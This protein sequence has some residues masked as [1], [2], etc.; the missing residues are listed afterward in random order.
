[1]NAPS[2]PRGRSALHR[3]TLLVGGY[4]AL[5]LLTI[6]VVALLPDDPAIVNDTVWVRGDIV[7]ASAL[8]TLLFTLRA[9]RGSRRAFL[10]L[11]IISAVM[12]VAVA[13]IVG[14]PGFLPLWMRVEQSVCGLLLLGVVVVVNG[15]HL[16]SVFAAG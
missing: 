11:R 14:L 12:L 4:L 7:A 8:L 3:V 1:M 13:V 2:D 16:R 15:R 10:R 9:A 6:G 5:S